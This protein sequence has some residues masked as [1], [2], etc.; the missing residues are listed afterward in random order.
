[1]E[2]T[3]KTIIYTT[4]DPTPFK[5]TWEAYELLKKNLK[6]NELVFTGD[7]SGFVITHHEP[8]N[9]TKESL[10]TI[11]KMAETLKAERDANIEWRA[12]NS[13]V[14]I[15]THINI[16]NFPQHQASLIRDTEK[17]FNRYRKYHK[18]QIER[19]SWNAALCTLDDMK[20]IADVHSAIIADDWKKANQLMQDADTDLR[21]NFPEEVWDW[22]NCAS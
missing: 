18:E 9:I 10:E 8:L 15:L 13:P 14:P 5:A 22:A 20:V 2:I 1:M 21:E 19:E 7:G 3:T 4:I 16:T 11:F 17:M 12:K 6:P